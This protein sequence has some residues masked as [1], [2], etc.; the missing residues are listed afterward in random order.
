RINRIEWPAAAAAKVFFQNFPMAGMPP[1]VRERFLSK[2]RTQVAE[3]KSAN[4]LG[5]PVTI[6]LIDADTQQLMDTIKTE[7]S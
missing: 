7:P 2:M 3:A 1:E 6:E 4:N 5:S